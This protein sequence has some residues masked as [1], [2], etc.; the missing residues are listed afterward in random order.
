MKI[1]LSV[2]SLTCMLL[3][4]GCSPLKPNPKFSQCAN[5]CSSK[6]DAC[7]VNASTARGIER[8]NTK[9]EKCTRPC[10]SK[11]PRYLK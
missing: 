2:I 3:L 7:M 11:Y 8:C 4:S 10:E 6:Q 1:I 5:A 9:L